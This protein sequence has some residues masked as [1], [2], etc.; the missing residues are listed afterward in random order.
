MSKGISVFS[1]GDAA[2]ILS[3]PR[4]YTSLFL[5]RDNSVS[6]IERGLYAIKGASEYEIASHI[7]VPAY[8]SLI[9][10]LR[11]HNLTE[12]MPN[13]IYVLSYK[14]HRPIADINGYKIIFKTVKKDL[15]FGYSKIDGVFVASPEKAVVDMIYLNAFIEYAAEAVESGKLNNT[16]VIKYA[17]KIKST[18]LKRKISQLIG[19]KNLNKQ[20]AVNG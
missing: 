15:M 16:L 5:R 7:I 20:G 12:Q 14:R 6:R 3:K 13:T 10:A 1:L 9:S 17:S 2:R 11:F 19:T 8:I 4:H 18:L